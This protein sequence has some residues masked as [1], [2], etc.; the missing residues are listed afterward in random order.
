MRF[1]QPRTALLAVTAAAVVAGTGFATATAAGAVIDPV[2]EQVAPAQST[3]TQPPPA[4]PN[5]GFITGSTGAHD[6]TM[7]RRP[8]GSYLVATTGDGIALKTSA[9]R[10][11]FHNAGSVWPGGAP[12]TTP[13][14]GGSRNLWAPDLSFHNGRY[15]LYYSASTFGSRR[16]AIF[17]ATS[18]TGA[19]GSWTHRGLV[20][21][22]SDSDNFNAID[23]NLIVDAQGQWWLSFGSFWSG[24]KLIRLDNATGLRSTSDPAIRSLASRPNAGGAVEAPFIFRHGSF[25]YLL[26]SFDLCCRGSDS[27]YRIMVGRSTSITGPYLDR[28]GTPLTAGG[29]TQILARH[30]NVIG[31]G[32]PA[33]M[34]DVDGTVLVYHYYTPNDSALLGINLLGFDTA[35]WPFVY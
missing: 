30:G 4:Y 31:P 2:A 18:P 15:Y 11:A 32:H 5:P 6:P 34:P 24:I 20:I 16:S 28:N 33:V 22:T 14:T 10:I 19:A 7:V 9:D 17:L 13:Y 27:T 1:R 26:V 35:G 29:G 3:P 25:Y 21:E 8:D 23:P 12:W